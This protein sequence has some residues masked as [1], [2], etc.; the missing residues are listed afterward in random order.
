MQTAARNSFLLYKEK[1]N[2]RNVISYFTSFSRK[3]VF[4]RILIE[5]PCCRE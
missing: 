3:Q 4:V 5:H 2:K 1:L